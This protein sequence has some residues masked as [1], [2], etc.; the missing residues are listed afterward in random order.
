MSLDDLRTYQPVELRCDEIL[1]DGSFHGVFFY[2]GVPLK[3]LL[4]TAAISK[5]ED[6]FK[7]HIDLGVLIENKDKDQ[8]VLSWGEIFYSNPSQIV[9]AYDASPLS[10][11]EKCQKCHKPAFYK[12]ILKEYHRPISFPKLIIADDTYTDRCLEEITTIRVFDVHEHLPPKTLSKSETLYSP[13]FE[14]T[15]KVHNELQIKDVSQ[16]ISQKEKTILH[17]VGDRG[18]HGTKTFSGFSFKD[19][20]NKAQIPPSLSMAILISAP[21]GYRS[22]LSYGEIF[23][24]PRGDRMLLADTLNGQDIN[25]GGEYMFLIPDDFMADRWVKAVS[26]I[27][28]ISIP[29]TK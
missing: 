21:D 27:Q 5:K 19:L 8:V 29:E 22:L 17:Q 3:N 13:Q 26:Q 6:T 16:Y 2:R 10:V 12:P 25:P 7:K 4:Q 24:S 18:Y 20:L 15:G 28:V 9:I 23:L 1:Q 14:I 11:H